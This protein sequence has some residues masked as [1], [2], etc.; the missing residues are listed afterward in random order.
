M[1]APVS[2]PGRPKVKQP[3]RGAANPLR[4]RLRPT[5]GQW[6]AWVLYLSGHIAPV[7]VKM[8]SSGTS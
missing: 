2:P 7:S 6:G 4:H 8:A 3:S 1:A 5:P